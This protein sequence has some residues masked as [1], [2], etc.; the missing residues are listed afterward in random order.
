MTIEEIFS[1]I[2]VL[3]TEHYMLRGMT[4]DDAEE[5]FTFMSDK[6]TM[7]FITPDPVESIAALKEKIRCQLKGF[8]ERK[9]IPWVII[10]KSNG[11]IVGKFSLHK[12]NMWH[13]KTE[14]GVVIRKA[15]Q[16]RG[17]MTEILRK[18]LA[19]GFGPLDLN[20]IVGDIFAAN[21][22]SEKLLK[23]HG[24]RKEGIMRQTDFDGSEFHDTVVYSLLKAEYALSD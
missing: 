16:N 19:F 15:Y 12:I 17:V 1:D 4:K 22:G 14:M 5:M 6:E 24:F 8:S 10:S 11:D 9:E 7:K 13:R 18:V 2:P 21:P 23:R 20:R 3:E